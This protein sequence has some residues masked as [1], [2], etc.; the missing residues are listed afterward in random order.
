MKLKADAT[1][2]KIY[3]METKEIS[4][5]IFLSGKVTVKD[6][7][8]G[9]ADIFSFDTKFRTICKQ[10][11]KNVIVNPSTY[12]DDIKEFINNMGYDSR[13]AYELDSDSEDKTEVKE[14]EF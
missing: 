3:V 11:F 5:I 13:I 12:L 7:K 1:V 6:I 4:D 2:V 10:S 9:V 14:I 8:N